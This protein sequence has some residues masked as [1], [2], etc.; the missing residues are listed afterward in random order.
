MSIEI[1][2]FIT[3]Y[4]R[5]EPFRSITKVP[6]EKLVE[7]LADLDETTA[8]GLS[9]FSDPEYLTRRLT[10]EQKIRDEFI[11]KGGKP[12]LKHPIYF[13]LGRNAEF[14]KHERNKGYR[15]RL[16]DLS[17]D[18]VSFTYG[19]SM[20][21]FNEDYRRLKGEGYQSELC[22]KVFKFGDLPRVIS[23]SDYQ[24]SVRLPIEA[25]VWIDLSDVE[26]LSYED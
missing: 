2:D 8:W 24:S 3:H 13:F 18:C 16:R 1:P 12:V 17:K 21:S 26:G 19:D 9:R 11:A 20:F 4:S 15:V 10:V 22:S 5:G 7:T 6:T 14:E 23:H 25:Q